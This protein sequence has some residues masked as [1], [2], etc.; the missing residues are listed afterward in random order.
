MTISG[1]GGGGCCLKLSLTCLPLQAHRD[2][3]HHVLL[4][5]QHQSSALL[6]QTD[7]RMTPQWSSK[8]QAMSLQKLTGL[9]PHSTVTKRFL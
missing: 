7:Q 4:Q 1:E 9:M 3:N 5:Q 8:P 6:N 2:E